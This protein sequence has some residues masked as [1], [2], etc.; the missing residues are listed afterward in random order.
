MAQTASL[1]SPGV[2]T[3]NDRRAFG[4]MNNIRWIFIEYGD[5]VENFHAVESTASAERERLKI[6]FFSIWQIS[7]KE[8]KKNSRSTASVEAIW[9]EQWPGIP[10]VAESRFQCDFYT[11]LYSVDMTLETR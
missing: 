10:R 2:I 3:L 8:I 6:F 11:S 5:L 7:A 1:E 9:I 4:K